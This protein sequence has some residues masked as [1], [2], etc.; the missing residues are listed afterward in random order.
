MKRSSFFIVIICFLVHIFAIAQE[1]SNLP[2]VLVHGILG[3]KHSMKPTEEFIKKYLPG[4]HV[5]NVQIGLGAS[6]SF[7]NMND[8]VAWFA[9]ELQ[10][11]PKLKDGCIIIAHSQGGLVSRYFLQMYDQ[12]KVHRYISWGSPQMGVFGTPGDYDE[13]YKWLDKSES[14]AYYALYSWALQKYTSVAGYWRDTLHYDSYM[15]YC[16]FLPCLNNERNHPLSEQFKK[17]I[18]D[19]SAMVLVMSDHDDIIEPVESCQF[20]F[21]KVG[22]KTEIEGL[23]DSPWYKDDNLGLKTLNESGRLHFKIAHCTH[24]GYQEDE[25]NFVENTL[26]YLL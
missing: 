14:W 15:K 18:C 9:Q 17:R 19:L 25:S 7:F 3:D 4:R 20:G 21:Y 22:S 2:I 1:V 24:T 12:P 8:Q 11:D 6:T 10:Q 26:P 13:R 16:R 5:K 23:Q